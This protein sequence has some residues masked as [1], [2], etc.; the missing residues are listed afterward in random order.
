[1]I[2]SLP[3]GI[4]YVARGGR[5]AAQPTTDEEMLE[6]SS[7]AKLSTGNKSEGGQVSTLSSASQEEEPVSMI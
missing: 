5:K 3:G 7:L 6:E 1:V 4:I 2:T